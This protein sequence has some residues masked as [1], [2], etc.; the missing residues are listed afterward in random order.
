M[1]GDVNNLTNDVNALKNG[2]NKTRDTVANLTSRVD[3]LQVQVQKK[4]NK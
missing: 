4:K 2:Q 3:S 1:Q